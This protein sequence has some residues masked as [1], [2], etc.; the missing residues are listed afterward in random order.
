MVTKPH[1]IIIRLS[2]NQLQGLLDIIVREQVNK[3]ELV[4]NA[5]NAYLVEKSYRH[6]NTKT[7]KKQSH[8]D[9]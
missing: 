7:N 4:R 9:E 2:E 6:E 8:K 5:I 1:K 3:S